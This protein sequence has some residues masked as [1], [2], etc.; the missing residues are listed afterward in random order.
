MRGQR[1]STRNYKAARHEILSD[2]TGLETS[3][4]G[5]RTSVLAYHTKLSQW[6]KS[7]KIGAPFE[8]MLG[9]ETA[10]MVWS[11]LSAGD[12]LYSFRVTS[13]VADTASIKVVPYVVLPKV[14]TPLRLQLKILELHWE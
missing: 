5:N 10:N 8:M 6:P 3:T 2:P 4:S 7:S 1:Y 11:G 14:A 12:D 9:Y 13:A